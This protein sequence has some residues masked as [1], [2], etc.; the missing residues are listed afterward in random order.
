IANMAGTWM[1]VIYGFAGMRVR[2]GVLTFAP[3][4]PPGWESYRFRL[5][6]QGRRL[7]VSVDGAG[8]R[9]ELL[10]GAPLTVQVNGQ[11]VRLEA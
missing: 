1:G 10:S 5:A 4:L 11:A 9:C 8:V 7:R 3:Y 6:F 2:D